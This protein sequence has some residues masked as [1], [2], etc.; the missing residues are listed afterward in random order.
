MI[1]SLGRTIDYVRISLTDRCNLRCVYC[2]PKEGV[3]LLKHEQMLTYEEILRLCRC[4]AGLGIHKIKLTG[5]EP[6]VRK[7]VPY[8]VKQLKQ[9]EGIQN[10]T[11]TTNGIL[12]KPQM[13]ALVQAGIDGI[14]V[15]LDTLDKERFKQITRFDCLE[16]V[17]EGIRTALCYPRVITKINCVPIGG[18][19]MEKT[20]LQMVKLAQKQKLHVRFIELMPI[21]MG[22]DSAGTGEDE[23]RQ[24]IEEHYGPLTAVPESLGN[25]P[26]V[27]Y[28][29]DG[30]LGNIGFISAVSHKFCETCNRIRLT[31]E[32]YLKNCLQYSDGIA[33]KPLMEQGI[34]EEE[35]TK[36]IYETIQK[37]PVGHRF[38]EMPERGD[39][40]NMFQIG[41]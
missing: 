29:L 16:E 23:L 4:F 25:G 30:F 34:T 20:V 37:K 31:S 5:G 8:L 3:P 2:M 36:I 35:L 17:L 1:D 33:L 24:I 27:Y 19:D 41:G 21:G 10:V 28:S 38:G 39:N 7:D 9:I 22:K 32:G 26:G 11:I 13:E 6:L 15:S 40:R 14:N 12:L 18:A